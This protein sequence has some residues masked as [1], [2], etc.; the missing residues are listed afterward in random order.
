M[1]TAEAA[2]YRVAIIR[3]LWSAKDFAILSIQLLMAGWTF[4]R[5]HVTII[6][7]CNSEVK[8]FMRLVSV[9]VLYKQSYTDRSHVYFCSSG[10]YALVG[11]ILEYP[12]TMPKLCFW[13][14]AQ[15]EVFYFDIVRVALANSLCPLGELVWYIYQSSWCKHNYT[16][17]V[18]VIMHGWVVYRNVPFIIREYVLFS[19]SLTGR[20]QNGKW[21]W[22]GIPLV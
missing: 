1:D 11:F 12:A 3:L 19:C 17:F 7:R 2:R 4:S 22:I 16:S 5:H 18:C 9:L 6:I 14:E 8:H 21:K 15:M 10:F 20:C 13:L